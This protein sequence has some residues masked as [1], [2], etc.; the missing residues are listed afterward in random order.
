ME[1]YTTNR[2]AGFETNGLIA[3]G[4]KA[5][6]FGKNGHFA[7]GGKAGEALAL[8]KLAINYYK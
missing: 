7:K 8:K 3:S 5:E 6:G 4:L 1:T 2:K